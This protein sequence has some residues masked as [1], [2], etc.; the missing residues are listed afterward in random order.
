MSPSADSI[1]PFVISGRIFTPLDAGNSHS[2]K[3]LDK[4]YLVVGKQ[5]RIEFVGSMLPRS[6]S[7]YKLRRTACLILAGFGAFPGVVKV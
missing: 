7:N 1:E 5:G 2:Y 3:Y 4:G 6:Y